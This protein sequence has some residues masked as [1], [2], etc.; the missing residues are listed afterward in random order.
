MADDL[1]ALVSEARAAAASAQQTFGHLTAE[2]LNWKPAP[3]AWSVAQCFD[4]LITI[5]AGYFPIMQSLA[6]GTY[7]PS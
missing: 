6:R 4:H 3:D 1:A 5:N 2:Q 7:K